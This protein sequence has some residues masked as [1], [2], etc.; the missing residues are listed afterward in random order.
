MT[1]EEAIKHLNFNEIYTD[2]WA[3]AVSMAKEALEKQIPK[4]PRI[5]HAGFK[6]IYYACPCC[7]KCGVSGINGE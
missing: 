1:Y 7:G 4:K 6:L 3:E 2:D 5:R